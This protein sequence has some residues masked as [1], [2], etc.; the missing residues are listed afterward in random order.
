ML[1]LDLQPGNEQE[2]RLVFMQS[3]I[4]DA[5]ES[6]GKVR[7]KVFA[8]VTSVRKKLTELETE[9]E[10]LRQALQEANYGKK[11]AYEQESDFFNVFKYKEA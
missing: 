11:N 6:M 1:L 3:Q 9:N 7:R 10:Y 8:E 2:N 4:D 5:I